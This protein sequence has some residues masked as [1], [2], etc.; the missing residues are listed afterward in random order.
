MRG[1]LGDVISACIV[2]KLPVAGEGLAQDGIQRFLHSAVLP[3]QLLEGPAGRVQDFSRWSDVPTAQIELH[4]S[5]ETLD[6]VLD[7]R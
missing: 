2:G 5:K 4:D 7:L 6:G 1:L 3:S